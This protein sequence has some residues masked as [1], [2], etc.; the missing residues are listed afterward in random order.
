MDK[1]AITFL[2]ILFIV[3]GC[4]NKDTLT[5]CTYFSDNKQLDLNIYSHYDEI[6]AIKVREVFDIP[7]RVI[8]DESKYNFIINQLDDS[9]R[10][11]D[12]LLVREYDVELSDIYSLYKT[13]DYLKDMRFNCE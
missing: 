13:K 11:E 1:K 9:Y 10:F 5:A 12:N 8:S 6:Y 7:Q 4:K 2:I 3:C